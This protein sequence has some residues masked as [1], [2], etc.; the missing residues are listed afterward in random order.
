[1]NNALL[2]ITSGIISFCIY[3]LLII[4]LVFTLFHSNPTHYSSLKESSLALHAISIEAIIDDK[5]TP[6]QNKQTASN[7]PLAGSGIKD[8]FDKIDSDTPSQNTPIGDNREKIEQNSK[9]QQLKDLQASAESL[10][11]NRRY[12]YPTFLQQCRESYLYFSQFLKS[13]QWQKASSLIVKLEQK[14]S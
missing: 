7:N 2:F 12:R 1:M 6:S 13:H 5:P 11:Q 8:M 10:C 14:F 3:F 4:A 9:E